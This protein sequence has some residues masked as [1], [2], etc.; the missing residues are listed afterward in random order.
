MHD[1]NT[2]DEGI[3]LLQGFQLQ[4][5]VGYP[6]YFAMIALNHVVP[7]F[8]LLVLNVMWTFTPRFNNA[9]DHPYASTLSVLV[10][11]GVCK[12]FTLLRIF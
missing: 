10:S 3:S 11:R 4:R 1:F 7:L 12:R 9:S 8:A 6:Y 2:S 5:G